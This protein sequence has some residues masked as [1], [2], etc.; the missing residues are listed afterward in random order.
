M[1]FLM[2]IVLSSGLKQCVVISKAASVMPQ[3]KDYR[4]KV[5]TARR[6]IT[7]TEPGNQLIRKC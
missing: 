5:R 2:E 7:R 1:L 6:T 4:E 3:H